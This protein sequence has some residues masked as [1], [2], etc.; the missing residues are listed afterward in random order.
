[1]PG[2][3][4]AQRSDRRRRAARRHRRGP[5]VVIDAPLAFAFGVGMVAAFNPCGFAMLP[6]YLAFFLGLEDRDTDASASV[7]EAVK[8]S[9]VLTAGFVLVFGGFG[10]LITW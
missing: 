6:A 2:R 8:V 4:G 1:R 3:P 7:F 5:P 9:A 10:A